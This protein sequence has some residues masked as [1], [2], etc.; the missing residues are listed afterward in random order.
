MVRKIKL[1]DSHRG[2]ILSQAREDYEVIYKDKLAETTAKYEAIANEASKALQK[3]Y[4]KAEMEV[5]QK[6]ESAHICSN[7][8]TY[9]IRQAMPSVILPNSPRYS[10]SDKIR[11]AYVEIEDRAHEELDKV[12]NEQEAHKNA[13]IKPFRKLVT[14]A[15]TLNEVAEIYPSIEPYMKKVYEKNNQALVDVSKEDI[16]AIKGHVKTLDKLNE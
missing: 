15:R 14:T 12:Y 7:L 5:L 8:T 11:E 6:Y 3:L 9:N 4:P 16:T 1:N 2:A 13:Y 10:G